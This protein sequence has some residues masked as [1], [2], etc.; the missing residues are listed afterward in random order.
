MK[1]KSFTPST[2]SSGSCSIVLTI[3]LILAIIP[4]GCD[5]PYTHNR[6]SD[7]ACKE[8]LTGQKIVLEKGIL[9]DDAWTIQSNEFTDFKIN[10]ITESGGQSL[11]TVK[12]ELRSGS[13]GLLV[14]GTIS[15]RMTNSNQV[16]VFLR[17]TP[18]KIQ[19]LGRW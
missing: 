13:R 16:V 15:Y 17:F 10:A 2:P 7:R 11:A 18:T 19:K 12:F 6:P 9:L 5:S 1:L 4:S 8:W 14:D 3:L